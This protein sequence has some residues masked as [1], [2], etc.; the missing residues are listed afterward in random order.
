MAFRFRSWLLIP[1]YK[2]DLCLRT[3]GGRVLL[4]W[5]GMSSYR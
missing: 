3:W 5:G 1:Q 4:P 2:S